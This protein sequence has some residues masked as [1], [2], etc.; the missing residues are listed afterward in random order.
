[1]LHKNVLS[2][3]ET[4]SGLDYELL[5][6]LLVQ[7]KSLLEDISDLQQKDLDS[8][9]KLLIDQKQFKSFGL[10][11]DHLETEG[12]E[13]NASIVVLGLY[14]MGK[15]KSV[16][17]VK[18]MTPFL[19]KVEASSSIALLPFIDHF[20]EK[21]Q[22]KIEAS[23]LQQRTK[24]QDYKEDLKEQIEFLKT[25]MLSEKALEIE[26]KLKFHFPEIKEQFLSAKQTHSK[27]E[28]QKF[29]KIIER[30]LGLGS[31]S[32][33]EGKT[34]KSRL[35]K[36]AEEEKRVSLD[37]AKT[38]LKEMKT[39][40]LDLFLTQLEFLNFEN[41]DFYTELLKK[42]EHAPL[43][44]KI[45]LHLKS[46]QY[47]QG[48]EFLDLNES[49]LLTDSPESIYNY[50]YTK[51]LFLLGAGMNKEAEEIFILIKEQKGN[52]RDIQSLL[53]NAK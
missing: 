1:M 2:M 9:F 12:L 44:T 50:Y 3:I 24:V 52:F 38:W 19:D 39:A 13:Y 41:P 40:D 22:K 21:V 49:F 6:E 47:L 23:L 18:A 7:S 32:N 10:I 26:E 48:L 42:S 33:D 20:P 46:E 14:K 5:E 16:D 34:K 53:Q 36:H 15:L 25:Q 17:D 4:S 37:L 30:N 11:V 43:W 8:L 45:L 51:G 29:A 31:S 35:T 28:E 27:T